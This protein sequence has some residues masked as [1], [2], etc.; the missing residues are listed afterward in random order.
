MIQIKLKPSEEYIFS[1]LD[2]NLIDFDNIDF[3]TNDDTISLPLIT[4]NVP[5]ITDNLDD[6][7]CLLINDAILDGDMWFTYDAVD[8]NVKALTVECHA[9]QST[10]DI[11]NIISLIE[12]QHPEYEKY[13]TAYD[14]FNALVKEHLKQ[15]IRAIMTD[16]KGE[17]VKD[18]FKEDTYFQ[19]RTDKQKDIYYTIYRWWEKLVNGEVNFTDIDNGEGTVFVALNT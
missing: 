5:I 14:N 3:D 17:F 15:Q 2:I 13:K 11:T 19:S 7:I 8:H 18:T 10:T 12:Y 9:V 1:L 16:V 4:S 6:D